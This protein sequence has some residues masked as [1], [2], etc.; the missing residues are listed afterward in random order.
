MHLSTHASAAETHQSGAILMTGEAT[1]SN[2]ASQ[3]QEI[4]SRFGKISVNLDQAIFFPRGLLGIPGELHFCLADFPEDRQMGSF[5]LLQCL[6]D[7]TLSFVVL[8]LGLENDFI[9]H[10]DLQECC[11]VTGI[12]PD[13]L[14]VLLIISVNRVPGSVRVTA[15][16]RA[17]VVVDAEGRFAGQYVFPTNKY[18][19]NH[20]LSATQTGDN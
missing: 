13:Q 9:E 16:L 5:R 14:L 4:E 6:N 8:P 17:P 19:I 7:H 3:H 1:Q 20:V 11:S 18:D 12:D 10:A 15:N 2:E